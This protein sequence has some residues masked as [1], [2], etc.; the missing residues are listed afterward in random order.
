MEKLRKIEAG[1]PAIDAYSDYAKAMRSIDTSYCPPEFQQAFLKHV[2]S[3]ENF[4]DRLNDRKDTQLRRVFV[5]I[6]GLLIGNPAVTMG[7]I[8]RELEENGVDIS[9]IRESW[10]NVESVS[11]KYGYRVRY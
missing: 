11:L 5:S 8:F 9:E 7:P 6:I 2:H 3:W 1:M 4:V 10:Q